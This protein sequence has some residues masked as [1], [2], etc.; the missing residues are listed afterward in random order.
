MQVGKCEREKIKVMCFTG[1][2]TRVLTLELGLIKH[3]GTFDKK[4]GNNKVNRELTGEKQIFSPLTMPSKV[5][6]L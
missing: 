3:R 5:E 4:V 1:W 6:D 2:K